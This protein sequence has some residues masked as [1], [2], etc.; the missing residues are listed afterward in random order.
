MTR[1]IEALHHQHWL[2]FR[3]DLDVDGPRNSAVE[4]DAIPSE[5]ARGA[6]AFE[7]RETAVRSE[8]GRRMNLESGRTWKIVNPAVRNALG[9]PVGYELVPGENAVPLARSGSA[10]L[11]RAGFTSAHVW[12]TPLDPAERYAAGD[13]P[14]QNPSEDGLPRWT[15]AGRSVDNED[16]VLWYTMGITHRPRPEEW[17]VMSVHRAGFRLVP[18]GFFPRNPGLDVPRPADSAR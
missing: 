17:P 7:A 15:T 12:V 18:S 13:Y 6:G 1:D 10:I 3:L 5:A 4:I 2:N 16:L 8:G 11:R 9:Q 14:N